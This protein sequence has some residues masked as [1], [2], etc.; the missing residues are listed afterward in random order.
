M[1]CNLYTPELPLGNT[2]LTGDH[3]LGR[4]VIFLG[5]SFLNAGIGCVFC[6]KLCIVCRQAG[7]L[8]ALK[9][10]SQILSWLS[11]GRKRRDVW[12]ISVGSA[13]VVT[14]SLS[15]LFLDCKDVNNGLGAPILP[16]HVGSQSRPSAALCMH[17]CLVMSLFQN[18]AVNFFVHWQKQD[19]MIYH[20]VLAAYTLRCESSTWANWP[21]ICL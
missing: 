6:N 10:Q 11:K 2:S 4:D 21:A 3:F 8:Q 9:W 12:R 19:S 13:M 14:V 5:V 18:W 16:W 17:P 7:P 15:L 20:C 1:F